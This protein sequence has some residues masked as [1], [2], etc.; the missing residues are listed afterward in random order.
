M[1]RPAEELG[2]IALTREAAV[3]GDVCH[4]G[5][6]VLQKRAADLETVV[7]H[8][9]DRRASHV[10]LEKRAALAAGHLAGRG[11]VRQR[12]LFLVM[13]VNEMDHVLLDS[14]VR[15]GRLRERIQHRR[16]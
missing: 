16:E 8:E 9:V 4:G 7:V 6:R 5:V 14:T 3:E 12:D 10:N 13:L 2:E 15:E 1:E 11:N